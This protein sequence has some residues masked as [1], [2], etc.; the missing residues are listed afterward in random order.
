MVRS[1]TLDTLEDLNRVTRYSTTTAVMMRAA[2]SVDLLV[3]DVEVNVRVCFEALEMVELIAR[4]NNAFFYL[5]LARVFRCMEFDW[6]RLL[7]R[8]F[9]F[10]ILI[11]LL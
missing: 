7:H 5:L 9:F 2:E 6:L 8:P 4:A 11:L 1:W 10:H 3:V